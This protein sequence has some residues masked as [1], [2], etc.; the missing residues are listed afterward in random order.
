MTLIG[1]KEILVLFLTTAPIQVDSAQCNGFCLSSGDPH[2]LTFDFKKYDFHGSKCQYV[3]TENS[4]GSC[5]FRVSTINGDIDNKAS[6]TK[7]VIIEYG[8]HTVMIG[9]NW[10]VIVDGIYQAFSQEIGGMQISFSGENTFVRIADCSVL[11]MYKPGW[12]A[13]V[14]LGG[15]LGTNDFKGK[16]KGL[17]GNCNGNFSDDQP[18]DEACLSPGGSCIVS[19]STCSGSTPT[20]PA[21]ITGADK[22]LYSSDNFCGLL[23][24]NDQGPFK[25]CLKTKGFVLNMIYNDCVF[26]AAV[27]K[28]DRNA[29]CPK[30]NEAS[31][32]CNL[33]QAGSSAL[34][35]ENM[36]SFNCLP[37]SS[38]KQQ[39]LGCQPSCF[40]EVVHESNC[41]LPSNPGCECDSGFVMVAGLCI[42]TSEC[43]RPVCQ[44]MVGNSQLMS[45]PLIRKAMKKIVLL[46]DYVIPCNSS[47]IRWNYYSH[48]GER[49]I[50][51]AVFRNISTNRGPTYTMVGKNS[52]P[53][54]NDDQ[55]PVTVKIPQDQR[56][57]VQEG[58]ILGFFGDQNLN[59]VNLPL[60]Y[61]TFKDTSRAGS[62]GISRYAFVYL[63]KNIPDVGSEL[64]V[65]MKRYKVRKY[66][67]NAHLV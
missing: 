61:E 25:E 51:G 36:C 31:M 63:E 24:N 67:L 50:Y 21:E 65:E 19:N 40:N 42:P 53:P 33:T 47:I 64:V 2:Y 66:S 30:L 41:S 10:K 27:L 12:H 3:M 26:D 62:D 43:E 45:R 29:H 52:L 28:G 59:D 5:R 9:S 15:K 49:G 44:A 11:V 13:Q 34:R 4:E 22:D 32:V 57:R 1:F 14:Q 23:K 35:T 20:K 58:D 16:L 38:F 48:G 8:G 6:Y 55:G 39:M 18:P 46:L 7:D 60:S 56:I 54:T 17:C 37:N